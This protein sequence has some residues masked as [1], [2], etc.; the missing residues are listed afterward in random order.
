MFS[1]IK[2]QFFR[3]IGLFVIVNMVASAC[4]VI[5]STALFEKR[6]N[7]IV[8]LT[9]DMDMSL[10]PFVKNTEA[11]IGEKGAT[12]TNYFI[13]DSLCCPSRS[14]NLRGQYPHNTKVLTND[15]PEGG[16][17]RF[18]VDGEEKETLAV[19][20]QRA[21]Y[22]TSLVGKYLN[23]YPIFAGYNYV[24]AGWNDWHAL[25]YKT[26]SD[27][28][29]WYNE[30]T[31]NE[32]GP[33]VQ[34]GDSPEN[35]STD[36]FK[37]KAFKFIDQSTADKDPFFLLLA[38]YAPHGPS[39][40]AER[41]VNLLDGLTYP[42]KPSFNEPDIS[43]KPKIIQALANTGD[44]VDVGDADTLY[45]QRA[46]T[47]LAVD[48]LVVDLVKKLEQNGQLDNTYI[49]FTSDN[50]F[51][52]GEHS[53]P[54]GKGLAYEEDIHVP[55]LVRGPGIKPN[56]V[57][58]QITANIDLASTIAEMTGAKPADF[59][60]GRSFLPLLKSE[61]SNS[62]DWRKGLL[63][64]MGKVDTSAS[65]VMPAV[66]HSDFDSSPYEFE[67]PD[68]LSDKFLQ[69]DDQGTYRGVRTEKFIYLEYNNGEREFYN[70]EKDPYE[71]ENLAS[72]L[73]PNI[74]A[75]LH[76][77]LGKLQ[78]CA[79]DECRKLEADMPDVLKDFP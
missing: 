73:D 61:V 18:F 29:S 12:L 49:F 19:W 66:A 44:V 53:L 35:Y 74:T 20:L 17:R 1:N 3:L 59:V 46:R 45:G 14:S 79:A 68:S 41:H 30:Y 47:M 76:A 16:F 67:Y 51:S 72:K 78:N 62:T 39:T 33:L 75:S 37:E 50:G 15:F 24:P 54:P 6:P 13:T 43:D 31:L 57:V 55:M 28:G 70:L 38:V 22:R 23:G 40:P 27:A 42:Q 65:M 56:T 34:Y 64:E 58:T 69:K 9:D 7:V 71:L 21:G 4:G 26:S 5:Q 25:F 11:L 48:E 60:D 10:M 77:W 8:V 52:I 63:I 36:V 2:F 32:N